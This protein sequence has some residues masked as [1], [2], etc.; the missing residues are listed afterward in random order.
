MN[1]QFNICVIDDDDIYQFT[2]LKVLESI[3]LNKKVIF[4]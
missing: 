2:I 1:K 4:F 3:K